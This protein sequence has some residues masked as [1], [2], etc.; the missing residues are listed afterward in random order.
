M[1]FGFCIQHMVV[2]LEISFNPW[3]VHRLPG[4]AKYRVLAQVPC[5]LVCGRPAGQSVRD[6]QA[7]K[8]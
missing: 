4:S 1:V 2:M 3:P 8:P 5:V 6:N 7:T